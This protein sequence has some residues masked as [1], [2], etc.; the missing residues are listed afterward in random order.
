MP[1]PAAAPPAPRRPGQLASAI[2]TLAV[3]SRRLFKERLAEESWVAQAGLRAPCYSVLTWI[4]RLEPVS[5]K[6]ISDQ[7]AFDPSDIVAVVDILE[8]AGF[9]ARRRD[10]DDR[11]RYSLG[12]TPAGR[13]ALRRLDAIALEVQD[14]VLAP[15]DAPERA[16]FEHLVHVVIDYHTDPTT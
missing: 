4:D 16:T 6:R 8:R 10:P 15:L 3:I 13:E 9:V 1:R 5:Q 14:A 7:I 11:R 12:L 2:T